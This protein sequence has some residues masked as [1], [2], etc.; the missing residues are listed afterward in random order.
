MPKVARVGDKDS[1]GDTMTEG[2]STVYAGDSSG[3]PSFSNV[4]LTLPKS[5]ELEFAAPVI[6]AAGRRATLDEPSE[7]NKVPD[8]YPEDNKPS[9]DKG[10]N[11]GEKTMDDNKSE[12]TVDIPNDCREVDPNNIAYNMQLSKNFTLYDFT[13]GAYFSHDIQAQGGRSVTQIIC[14]LQ[15]L[16]R[17]IAEPILAEFGS[18][19]INSGFRPG[20]GKSQHERG[21]GMDIQWPGISYEEYYK[22]IEWSAENLVFDQLICEH[23]NSIWEH[24]S[25]NREHSTQRN[26][27]LTM[28]EGNYEGGIVRYYA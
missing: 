4:Q 17:N 9:T 22:R 24:I 16:A 2:S 21:Q 26:E 27:I 6:Q 5:Y 12:E 28:Y 1:D 11:Q 15:A 3:S 7:K 14:N 10:Q 8:N 20:T 23:G 13:R 18:F 19:R 25:F